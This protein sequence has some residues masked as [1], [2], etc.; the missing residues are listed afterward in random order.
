MRSRISLVLVAVLGLALTATPAVGGPLA[1][2]ADVV[3]FGPPTRIGT[4]PVV[5]F[6]RGAGRGDDR[7]GTATWRVVEGTG[8]CC[9]T[10]PYAAPDG[11]LYDFGGTFINFTPDRG[12][13]WFRVTPPTPLVNGEGTLVYAPNGDIL[14][15]GWDPY[16]GDHL[17]AYKYDAAADAWFVEESPLHQPFYDREW[18]A[19]VPGP[20]TVD[21]EEVPYISFVK[22]GWPTKEFWLWSSDGLSYRPVSSKVVDRFL[23]GEA[24]S[25]PLPIAADAN[26]DWTQPNTN[27]GIVPLGA[28]RALA[29]PDAGGGFSIFDPETF[30]WVGY[31]FADGSAPEGLFQVDSRGRLHNVVTSSPPDGFV[32]RVSS[33]GG[34]SWREL[35]VRTPDGEQIQELDFHA[36]G[37][38]SLAAV[39]VR[40]QR[41]DGTDRDLVF[42]LDVSKDRPRLTRRYQ[43]GLGDVGAASGVG[44]DSRFDFESVAIL[45]DGRVAV[46]FLDST[47]YEMFPGTNI[48]RRF[49]P[50]LAIELRTSLDPKGRGPR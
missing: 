40:A 31:T 34:T 10:Y 16:S 15:I 4:Y 5:D 23:S 12:R 14:G 50:A 6:G 48:R 28:G 43:V 1:V 17:Q 36:N 35:T 44:N 29:A 9:E 20:F 38:L 27:T 18:L 47:T 26:S 8:N 46:S 22:G 45:P 42:K 41:Q 21:G 13:T 11:T 24:A 33:D 37:G 49:V 30:S 19:V 25:E 32:Y 2:G 7:A 3:E 39:A